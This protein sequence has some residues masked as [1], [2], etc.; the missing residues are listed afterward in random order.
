[1]KGNQEYLKEVV[2]KLFKQVKPI[3]LHQTIEKGHGRIETRNCS[4]INNLELLYDEKKRWKKLQSV[5][6]IEAIIEM[7]GKIRKEIRYFISSLPPDAQ[8]LNGAIRKHWGIE[9]KLHWSLDVCFREDDSRKRAEH[10]AE[11]FSTVRKIAL[12]LLKQEHTLKAGMKG[13]RLNAAWDNEYLKK[14]LG[15]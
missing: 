14:I 2:E 6:S 1:L 5:V 8:L 13:K 11:N 10:S 9:I 4:V 12:N 3:A 15:I 7:Q